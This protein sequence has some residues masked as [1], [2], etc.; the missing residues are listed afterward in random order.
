MPAEGGP[1]R[2][3]DAEHRAEIESSRFEME[4]LRRRIEGLLTQQAEDHRTRLALQCQVL[5]LTSDLKAMAV[6]LAAATQG[7]L[8]PEEPSPA[9]DDSDGH[10]STQG[11]ERARTA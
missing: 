6:D 7:K 4:K 5:K 9:G 3:V 10:L 11:G 8:A 1:I 2:A